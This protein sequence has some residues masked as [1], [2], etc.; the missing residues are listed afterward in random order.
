MAELTDKFSEGIFKLAT[1]AKLNGSV[2]EVL[3]NLHKKKLFVLYC[4]YTLVSWRKAPEKTF[5]T[6][7]KIPLVG[8]LREGIS[9]P[10]FNT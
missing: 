8:K 2:V 3:Y 9:Y 7:V 4:N 10:G 1:D 5:S 6:E